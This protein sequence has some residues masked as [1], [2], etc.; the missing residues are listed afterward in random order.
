MCT[1]PPLLLCN[2]QLG[3]IYM[4]NE[5]KD[6]VLWQ[7]RMQPEAKV[8]PQKGWTGGNQ[9]MEGLRRRRAARETY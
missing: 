1:C 9:V 6:A 2:P 7:K 5:C 4:C 3:V 8:V